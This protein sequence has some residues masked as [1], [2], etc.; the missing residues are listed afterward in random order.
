MES[1]AQSNKCAKYFGDFQIES[2]RCTIPIAPLHLMKT[3]YVKSRLF[4]KWNFVI[5]IDILKLMLVS[6]LRKNLWIHQLIHPDRVLSWLLPLLSAL[7][8]LKCLKC[9]N[10]WVL[11]LPKNSSDLQVPNSSIVQARKSLLSAQVPWSFFSFLSAQVWKYPS[12]LN[13]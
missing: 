9:P 4:I 5:W 3:F 2:K 10:T 6:T 11:Q 13:T 12:A 1:A 8:R 7:K